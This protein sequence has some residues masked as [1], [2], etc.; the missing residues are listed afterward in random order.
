MAWRGLHLSRPARLSLAD[1]QMVIE[2]ADG[3]VRLSIEDLAWVVLDTPQATLTAALLSACMEGGVAVI[4]TGPT[5][6]PN[7][8]MLPFHAH[9]RQSEVARRQVT[10]GEPLRK[11]LWQAVVRGKI[12]NQAAVLA[13]QGRDG[14]RTVA[15]MSRHV[16]SGDPGNVEAR[17]AR[18]Y[19]Q[20]LFADFRREDESDRRNRL[21]NYGYAVARS[22]VA[23]AL[24]ASGLLPA[25]GINHASVSNAFN[26]ADDL[27]EPFRPFADMLA[28]SRADGDAA[29][30]VADRQAMAGVLMAE[31]QMGEDTMTLLAASE[32]AAA[33][34]VR[35]ITAN[36]AT[37]LVLPAL[38]P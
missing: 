35:A 23:R 12:L 32:Q 38:P 7:G 30:S 29:L 2:Q 24:A 33:S 27:L 8:A 1:G 17:A 28:C 25:F 37:A 34:L 13:A 3:T 10:M 18:A 6:L 31:V 15:E 14:G 19:W 21:L 20:A 9:Y 22:A 5:H 26:L 36:D 11:R 16:G 4:S